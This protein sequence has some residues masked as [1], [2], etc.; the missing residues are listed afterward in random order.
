MQVLTEE[1]AETFLEKQGFPVSQR[2]ISSS[3][4][5]CVD[6]ARKI[7]YP[8]VLKV[9]SKNILHKSD[10]GGVR[11]DVRN[12]EEVREQVDELLSIRRAEAVMVEPFTKGVP[13]LLGLKKDPT[14]GHTIVVGWGD[15][16]TEV[17]KDVALRVCPIDESEAFA[18]LDGLKVNQLLL[19][20]RGQ[21]V[22]DR[23]KVAKLI[24]KLSRLPLKFPGLQELDINPLLVA[25][26]G[27]RIVDARIVL[28]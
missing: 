23:K 25:V 14:F 7:G 3:K 11:L 19:G 16:Y 22:L 10:V 15:I 6:F 2:F 20:V 21:S 9:V 5:A 13:L 1:A 12:D 4:V 26:D 8:I 28:G 27:L 24:V 17:L 18:M